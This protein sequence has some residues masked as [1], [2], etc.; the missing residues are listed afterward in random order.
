MVLTNLNKTILWTSRSFLTLTGYKPVDILGKTPHFLQGPDT[1]PITLRFIGEQLDADQ[2]AE[3][4]LVNYRSSGE[5]YL[6]HLQIEPMC[7]EQGETTHFLAV[8]YDVNEV[9]K[10]V[11]DADPTPV[12]G[13]DPGP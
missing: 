3:A 11:P 12:T 2:A 7:N 10:Q 6:C 8:E 9:Y 5:Q 1:D 4:E 13:V